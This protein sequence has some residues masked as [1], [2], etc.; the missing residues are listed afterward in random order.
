M[1]FN[2]HR[3]TIGEIH[4][5]SSQPF[6]EEGFAYYQVTAD[7]DLVH[8]LTHALY[9]LKIQSVLV[10]GGARLLQSFIDA[11]QWD[12]I[13]MITN[14]GLR[15][16]EGIASPLFNGLKTEETELFSDRIETFKPI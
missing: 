9:Q 11:N 3:H 2:R 16:E 1:I 13:R 5:H 4:F 6:G 14:T 7:V 8:Q 10:E 15:M 12:E